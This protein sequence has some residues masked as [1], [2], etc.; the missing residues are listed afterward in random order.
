MSRKVIGIVMNGV[1][2]RM[3][4]R[5]HLVRSVL[6]IREQGGLPLD[7]GTVIWPEPIL[8]GRSDRKLKELADRHGLEHWT[9]DLDEALAHPLAE[10]YFDAQVTPAREKAIRTAIAASTSTS[11]PRSRPPS[12]STPHWNWPALHARRR[13]ATAPCRTSCSCPAC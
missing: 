8:V 4:Y 10:I 3:G 11:T 9:T 7:D 13:C 5:Q 6:A 12:P 1:T 2:G